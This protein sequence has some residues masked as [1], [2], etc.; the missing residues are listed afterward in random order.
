MNLLVNVDGI[1]S[2]KISGTYD[3]Q[4]AKKRSVP[5]FDVMFQSPILLQG[6]DVFKMEATIGGPPSPYG[7]RGK[8]TVKVR[9]IT[10]N[11]INS[12]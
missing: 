8:S 4:K 10:V 9:G 7:R 12:D 3:P 2:Y 11:F 6:N 5:G 1:R